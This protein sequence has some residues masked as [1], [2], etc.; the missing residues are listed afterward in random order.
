MKFFPDLFHTGVGYPKNFGSHA[1]FSK[2]LG[3][4]RSIGAVDSCRH[5]LTL[6]KALENFAAHTQRKASIM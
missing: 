4:Y 3:E 5:A 1:E 6:R 2:R